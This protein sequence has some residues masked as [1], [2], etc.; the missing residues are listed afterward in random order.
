MLFQREAFS[1][2]AAQEPNKLIPERYE[3]CGGYPVILTLLRSS[4]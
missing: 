2:T 1:Y 4:G 3:T